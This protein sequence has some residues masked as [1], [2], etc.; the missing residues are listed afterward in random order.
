MLYMADHCESLFVGDD[1]KAVYGYCNDYEF[2]A[3][4]L[5]WSSAKYAKEL[6]EKVF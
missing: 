5:W 4:M 2:R 6:P 3:A 1:D